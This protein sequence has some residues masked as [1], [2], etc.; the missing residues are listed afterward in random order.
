MD[1]FLRPLGMRLSVDGNELICAFSEDEHFTHAISISE[2]L[3]TFT[4]RGCNC[5]NRHCY[6]PSLISLKHL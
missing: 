3:I 5:H 6:T 2:I 1:I 4:R